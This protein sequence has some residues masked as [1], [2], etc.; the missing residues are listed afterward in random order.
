MAANDLHDPLGL[1]RPPPGGHG[2]DL[3][4]GAIAIGGIAALGVGLVAFAMITD[5]GM[6][7]LPFAD[8]AIERPVMARLPALPP[9]PAD[10]PRAVAAEGPAAVSGR[11][12]AS[13][14]ETESGV[15]V[16]RQGGGEVP[17]ALILQ[18][19]QDPL[20]VQLAAAPDPR[21][22]EKGRYGSLP[23]IGA[24]GARASE[25]YARPLIT[26]PTLKPDAPR[27]ALV[28]GGMGLNPVA[29]TAAAEALPGAVTL[30]FAPYGPDLDRQVTRARDEGHEVILQIPMEPYDQ[31]DIPGPH[32]LLAGAETS[33]NLDHLRWFLSRM[34]GYVGVA[35]FLGGKF[36]ARAE[37]LSPVMRELA[38]RGLLYFDDGTSAQSLAMSL[39]TTSGPG[40]A[41]ADVVIDA[42]VKSESMEAAFL[43]LETIAR[44]RG[45]AIGYAAGLPGSV[46]SVARFARALEKRGIA[47]VPLSVAT[48][49][50]AGPTAGLAQ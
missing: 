46:D 31:A 37:D 22:V 49:R 28:L 19:P 18:V 26:A 38:S 43:R 33:Q 27:I 50:S 2:R 5:N 35:N 24:D 48:A 39:A 8:V 13:T 16:V 40:T 34:T 36:T 47:L 4:W 10:Q 14:V 30:G 32:T 3:P 12:S 1:D 25:I 20:G 15:R 21:L 45:V 17:G 11:L 6:G 42:N 41:R 44:S 23:R 29:T 9:P 7:G